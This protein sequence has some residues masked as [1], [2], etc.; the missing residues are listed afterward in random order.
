[1]LSEN[2]LKVLARRYLRRDGTG[3]LI[4]DPAGMFQRVATHVA[5]AEKLYRQGNELPWREKFYRVMSGLE[6][7]PNSPTLMNAGRERGQLAA[8]FVLPVEDSMESIFETLKQ[9]ALIQQSGGGTGFSFSRLRPAGDLVRSTMGVA[10]GPLSFMTVYDVATEVIKQGSAR[11]GANM[12]V[13][14]IDH[15]DVEDFIRAK[16]K[17][18]RLNNFNLS[19]GVTDGFME[20]VAGGASFSLINP[21]TG[22]ETRRVDARKLFDLLTEAAWENGE[23][24]I[25]FLDRINVANPTPALG[26]FESTNPCGEQPLL[27]YESCNLGSLNLVKMLQKTGP[28]RWKIDFAKLADTIHTAVRFLDNVIDVNYFPLAD[29]RAMTLAN[30]KIGLGVMGFADMLIYLGIPYNSA[31]AVQTA[32]TLMAFITKTALAASAELAEER[33]SFPNFMRSVYPAQRVSAL[34]NATLTTIAP[35]GTI[36]IIAGCSSGIEPLFAVALS[37]NV[38]DRDVLGD[39]NPV[40]LALAREYGFDQP[41]ILAEVAREGTIGRGEGIPEHVRACFV[42]AHDIDPRWHI[43][44][45]AAFQRHTHN[46]VSKT[47]NYPAAASVEDVR[48][49]FWLAFQ[50]RCKG[51]TVY[52]DG[53]RAEQVLSFGVQTT[54]CETITGSSCEI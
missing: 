54:H 40:F 47:I 8:C 26:K 28:R 10:S 48:R 53:S 17:R 5:G 27:P 50:H 46:A 23:P 20:A 45:Q 30:R 31:E 4:E 19:V 24:G 43:R 44:M 52:R 38:L 36:S 32:E 11:R 34:R 33:G 25:L 15:P 13:L 16:R 12:A 35:T 41:E 6:F 37:R 51:L 49:G 7:L 9:T 39:I 2:A 21:R 18:D 22:R 14:R 1:M 42:T 29:V 3:G